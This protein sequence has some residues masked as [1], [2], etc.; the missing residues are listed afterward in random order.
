LFI[1]CF[2]FIFC[3]SFRFCFLLFGMN[4]Y[5]HIK[6]NEL[7]ND[8]FTIPGGKEVAHAGSPGEAESR[9]GHCPSKLHTCV[10]LHE[11]DIVLQIILYLQHYKIFLIVAWTSNLHKAVPISKPTPF[12]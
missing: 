3:F 2:I 8:N 11:L 6:G 4:K 9:L 10:F 1:F 12:S 5:I 7:V